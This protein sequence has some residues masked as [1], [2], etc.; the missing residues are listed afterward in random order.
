M[1]E[2]A[3]SEVDYFDICEKDQEEAFVGQKHSGCFVHMLG[4]KVFE[5]APAYS[6]TVECIGCCE[7]SKQ[8]M[9]SN[10]APETAS[11]RKAGK[12][13]AIPDGIHYFQSY[14]VCLK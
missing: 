3:S 6:R 8:A 14:V 13:T 9:Q 7:E 5:T 4:W 1:E 11:W 10:R 12:K 2:G